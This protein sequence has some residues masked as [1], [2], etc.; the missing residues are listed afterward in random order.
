[1]QIYTL[2][3]MR[4]ELKSQLGNRTD[5]LEARYDRWINEAVVQMADELEFA[6]TLQSVSI[7]TVALQ[8]FYTLATGINTILAVSLQDATDK[9]YGGFPLREMDLKFYREQGVDTGKPAYWMIYNRILVL[10]PAP[11]AIYT[12]VLDTDNVSSEMVLDTDLV[13]F[14]SAVSG[15]VLLRARWNANDAL[16]QPEAA[17]LAQNSYITQL[18]MRSDRLAKQQE[19]R[20]LMASVPRTEQQ[21]RLGNRGYPGH[22]VLKSS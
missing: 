20:N 9:I 13:P 4:A 10:W 5:V 14:R 8:P 18:R 11:D 2:A 6:D 16:G 1:M 22:A 15:L 3:S 12:L 21:L 17:A 7:S 19:G